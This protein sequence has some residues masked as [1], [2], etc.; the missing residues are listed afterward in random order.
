M[1]GTTIVPPESQYA[2]IA[3]SGSFLKK[4][5]EKLFLVWALG[6]WSTTADNFVMDGHDPAGP[7]T[8]TH[9]LALSNA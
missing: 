9:A 7:A 4:S 6:A 2:C 8:A 5:T 3:G 1:L